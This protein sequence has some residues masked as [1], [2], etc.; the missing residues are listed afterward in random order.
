MKLSA[1]IVALNEE[2]N[3]ERAIRS[4]PF[5]DE[6]L[7][8]DSGS[9]DRTREIAAR[10][11]ARVIEE[12]WRGYAAQKN[13][14]AECAANLWILSLDADEEVGPELAAEIAQLKSEPPRAEGYSFPRLARYLGKWIRH[15]GWYPDR[16]VRLYRR[17]RARWVGDYVHESVRVDGTIAELHGDLLHYTCDSLA[18]H[19]RTLDRYTTLAAREV[20][21]RGRRVGAM[22]LVASPAWTFLRSYFLQLGILDGVAGLTIARMAAIYTFRK[23]SK[24]REL[25]H[26]ASD[27]NPASR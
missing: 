10:L 9:S 18:E 19:F 1:T 8:V 16:K 4:I 24:A 7:V 17:D 15:S 2:R 22:H 3:I 11:G 13:F 12:P 23:Y 6:V 14:A 25:M 27:A 26:G 21:A 5:A 20:R